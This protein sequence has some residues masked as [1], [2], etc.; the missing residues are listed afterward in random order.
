MSR[1]TAPGGAARACVGSGASAPGYSATRGERRR[2]R[3]L[4]G[5]DGSHLARNTRAGE[6]LAKCAKAAETPRYT[7]QRERRDNRR[8]H[9]QGNSRSSRKLTR[10]D[11]RER[12]IPNGTQKSGLM[13]R[14]LDSRPAGGTLAR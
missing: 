1:R 3:G 7:E 8:W 10:P 6:R 5:G 11:S 9:H 4:R 12:H 13:N 14:L 2:C